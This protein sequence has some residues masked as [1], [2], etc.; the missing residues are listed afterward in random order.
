MNCFS[1]K[2]FR[3]FLVGDSNPKKENSMKALLRFIFAL[4]VVVCVF[5]IT[6]TQS[7]DATIGYIVRHEGQIGKVAPGPHD[8]TGETI[9]YGFFDDINDFKLI[10]RKRVL[11]PGASIGWHTQANDEVYY[12]ASGNGV[13]IIN[14]QEMD[15]QPGDAVLTRTG[16]THELRQTGKEDLVIFITY[17]KRKKD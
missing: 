17:E 15:F 6:F 7:K 2:P 1:A 11:H 16:S 3:L 8:G 9:G 5:G 14:G 12:C 13:I 4:S 10:F